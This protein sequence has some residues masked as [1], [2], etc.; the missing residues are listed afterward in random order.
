MVKGRERPSR[1]SA[2]ERVLRAERPS[3]AAWQVEGSSPEGRYR[4]VR[5]PPAQEGLDTVAEIARIGGLP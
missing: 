2:A 4:R 3:Q 1:K 5:A